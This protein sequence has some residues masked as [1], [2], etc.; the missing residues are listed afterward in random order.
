MQAALMKAHAIRL[1]PLFALLGGSSALAL[2]PW[3]V[4]LADVGPLASAFWRLGLAV[5]M[6]AV[7]ALVL[8]QP[9]RPPPRR[10]FLII[11][12]AAAFFAA[13]LAFWHMGIHLTKLGNATLF[14]N[15]G[16]FAFAIY[17]L[18]LV[19][20][21]PTAG[22]ISALVLA[23]LGTVLLLSGSLELSAANLRGDLLTLLAGLLYAGYLIG[24]DRAR[25]STPPLTLLFWATSA[26]AL[27][28]LPV[29]ATLGSGVV[30][31]NWAVL[32]ALAFSSQLVGQGLLVY[33]IGR[34]PPLVV[35]LG[36]LTQPAISGAIG[37]AA[38]G[39]FFTPLDWVGA[40]SIA[41]A[42]VLVRLRPR[43]RS[44]TVLP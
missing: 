22:Q 26:G 29:A 4:R 15:F 6:L 16:S 39:E 21:L 13:D 25:A 43:A 19:R 32:A 20:K 28:L 40:V 18:I 17:G 14:G 41:A 5:P 9:L 27:F 1:L 8:G 38:Y 3:L 11:V 7:A 35:G 23:A 12:I 2:G 10:Q 36:L 30:P 34:L 44:A 42:L 24:V 37:W 33:A 31:N